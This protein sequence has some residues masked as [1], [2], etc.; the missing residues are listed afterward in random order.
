MKKRFLNLGMQP[1]AN[2]FLVSRK[3]KEFKY[4]LSIGFNPKNFLVSLMKTVNPKK[5]Y[6]RFYAHR[7]SESKTMREAFKTVA[8]KL[9]KRFKPKLTM[10]IG[11]I[12]KKF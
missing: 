11:S 2:S 9:D 10:E 3:K 6:T 7:A 5:Q 8:K 4:N 1:L 12:Y